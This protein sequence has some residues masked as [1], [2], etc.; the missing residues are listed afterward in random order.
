MENRTRTFLR[1]LKKID[2][3]MTKQHVFEES[4][5]MR[6]ACIELSVVVAG[7]ETDRIGIWQY[8]AE[9]MEKSSKKRPGMRL[10]T[11]ICP[12]CKKE[13]SLNHTTRQI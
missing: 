12:Q 1:T 2:G 7:L 13:F 9:D 5:E 10:G 3:Y 6:Q 8:D 4:D 11:R